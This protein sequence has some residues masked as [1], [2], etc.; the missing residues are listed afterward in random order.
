MCICIYMSVCHLGF[1]LVP[2][3]SQRQQDF[4]LGR[5]NDERDSHS[6]TEK[7]KDRDSF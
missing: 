3:S 5:E 6:R 2:F 4:G 7:Q 1:T